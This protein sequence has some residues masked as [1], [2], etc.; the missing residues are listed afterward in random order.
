ML[1]SG[2]RPSPF[3]V[4]AEAFGERVVDHADQHFVFRHHCDR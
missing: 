4:V 1:Y 3:F 2:A